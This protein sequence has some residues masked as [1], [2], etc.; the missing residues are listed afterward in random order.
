MIVSTR[1]QHRP[2]WLLSAILAL[3]SMA[4]AQTPPTDLRGI[5]IYTNDVSQIT[6]STASALTAS[7]SVPGVDGVAVVIGWTAIEPAMG[8]YQWATL[9]QWIGRAIATGRKIDLVVPA[10]TS[11]P[12]WLFQSAPA[13]A[14]ATP[15]NFTDSPHNGATGVC[16]SETIA[17][18]WD[19]VFLTQWNSMLAALAAHLT[20]AGTYDAITLVRLTGINQTTEELRLPAET[21]QSTGLACVTNAITTWQQAGYGP[22]RLQQAWN[23]IVGS[24]QKNF[25]GKTFAVSLIPTAQAFPPIADNGS[26]IT[27]ALPNLTQTLLG[28]ASQML[29]GKLVVQFDFLMPGEAASVEVIQAA[30]NFGTMAAFQTNE[31][32][33]GQGA[34]CSEPV[35]NPAPCTSATFLQML[36]VGIYPLGQSNPIRAQYIEVFHENATAFPDAILQGHNMLVPGPL[37]PGA[38]LIFPGGTVPIY[39]AATSIQPGSWSSIYGSHLATGTTSWMGDFPTSL[40]GTSVAI[41]GKLAYLWVV[42]P[43]QINFQAPDDTAT[44]TVPVVVTIPTGSARSTVTLEQFAPSWLVQADGKHA[45]AIVF[46]PGSPGNSGGGWDVIGPGRPVK[47]GETLVVYGVGFGPVKAPVLAG[48]AYTNTSL[49]SHVIPYNGE[50][51]RG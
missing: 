42:S 22:A 10:G 16:N 25:P 43:G 7:L 48:Q 17:A 11:T 21:A 14:G 44:G 34:A 12:A 35:T 8:Q 18:P 33:G 36:E 31:Y 1:M 19:P 32:L 20:S 41:N 13:G 45:T 39:S 46:T 4:W 30:Q 29:P 9:D 27:G 15:L 47:A 24:F 28:A 50:L 37:T 49:L 5:Y 2:L 40:G 6:A 3:R 26:I 23:T 38:P 51:C